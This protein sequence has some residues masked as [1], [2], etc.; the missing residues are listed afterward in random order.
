MVDEATMTRT[1]VDFG[2]YQVN[3]GHWRSY[4]D[5]GFAILFGTTDK[6]ERFATTVDNVDGYQKRIH[7][8]DR[9]M[10]FTGQM[11]WDNIIAYTHP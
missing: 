6:G 2:F 4:G 11:A 7:G 1:L 9:P 5:A 3:P 10:G 8:F